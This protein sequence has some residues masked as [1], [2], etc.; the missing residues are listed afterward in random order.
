MTVLYAVLN[1]SPPSMN[2]RV[3]ASKLQKILFYTPGAVT[4]FCLL[5]RL[6]RYKPVA[7]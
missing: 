7:Q 3:Y 2:A 4:T 6:Q 1:M 5:L